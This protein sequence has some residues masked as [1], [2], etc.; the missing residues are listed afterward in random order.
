ME[1]VVKDVHPIYVEFSASRG[2][3]VVK[4]WMHDAAHQNV[5]PFTMMDHTI[6]LF[7]RKDVPNTADLFSLEGGK[8]A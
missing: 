8:G 2:E 5:C 7:T 1:A 6:A 4:M 3:L